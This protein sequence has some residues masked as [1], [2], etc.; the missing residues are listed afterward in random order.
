MSD[1]LKSSAG[2]VG[3]VVI[4]VVLAM[5]VVLTSWTAKTQYELHGQQEATKTRVDIL[6]LE[7]EKIKQQGSPAIVGITARLDELTRGQARIEKALDDHM[8]KNQP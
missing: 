3:Q 2:T 8:R 4:A 6:T 5:S 7:L 1:T